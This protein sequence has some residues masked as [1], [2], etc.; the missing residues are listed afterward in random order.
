MFY[1]YRFALVGRE[2]WN[3][4]SLSGW[5]GDLDGTLIVKVELHMFGCYYKDYTGLHR[6]TQDY[7]G[8]KLNY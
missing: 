5:H 6:I 1:Q 7:T 2:M 3:V 8:L 4:L